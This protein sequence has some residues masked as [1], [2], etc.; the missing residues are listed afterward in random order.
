MMKSW[1]YWT[2]THFYTFLPSF[3]LPLISSSAKYSSSRSSMARRQRDTDSQQTACDTPEQLADSALSLI[4]CHL[5]HSANVAA[6]VVCLCFRHTH[7]QTAGNTCKTCPNVSCLVLSLSVVL[8]L[9]IA[10]VIA[11]AVRLQQWRKKRRRLTVF[12]RVENQSNFSPETAA[13][14][15]AAAAAALVL[16]ADAKNKFVL[17]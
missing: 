16:S 2:H 12:V 15:S 8:L 4:D 9:I 11:T 1:K 10:A 14:C 13:L 5:H 3:S 17:F 7:R 6:T